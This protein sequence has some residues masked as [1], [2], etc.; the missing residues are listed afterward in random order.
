MPLRAVLID[1]GGVL[2]EFGNAEGLP[3]GRYDFRGREA[4]LA[5]LR[6]RG[7][8]RA[9][10]A[11]A[12]RAEQRFSQDELEEVLFAPWK[13]EH[14]RRHELGREADWHPHLARLRRRT[15]RR[16]SDRRLLGTWFAP[17]A[18]TV[19]PLPGAVEALAAVQATGRPL[20]L[21]SN[22]PLPA[23]LY[24]PLL[25]RHGMLAPFGV[26]Q[27]SYEAGSR[28]PSPAMLLAALTALGVPPAEAIMVG[29]RRSADVAAGRSAGV[30]TVWLRS[31][32][33][34]GPVPDHTIE[35]MSEL[36]ALVR[37]LLAPVRPGARQA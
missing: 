17:F 15:R 9:R 19:A 11:A 7:G 36:P 26:R 23:S 4:L 21:V 1:M 31:P 12:A 37:S 22:I 10:T 35:A 32:D 18:E 28:K 34:A 27:F 2:L 20:A 6:E 33:A 25:A 13:R 29:D 16:F 5:L 8:V 30:R 24:E 3:M 14:A